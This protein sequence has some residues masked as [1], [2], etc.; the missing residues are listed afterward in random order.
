MTCQPP[1]SCACW[2][3]ASQKHVL[4]AYELSVLVPAVQRWAQHPV[5]VP[6]AVLA[7]AALAVLVVLQLVRRRTQP[8]Y[9]LDFEC[10]R[11]GGWPGQS[12]GWGTLVGPAASCRH[13]GPSR[14]RRAALGQILGAPFTTRDALPCCLLQRTA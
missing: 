2:Y 5:T 6:S 7:G 3:W 13:C 10:F 11:P 12:R 1:A 9:L 14:A 8:V 4:A